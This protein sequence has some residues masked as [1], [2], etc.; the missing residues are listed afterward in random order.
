MKVQ[1]IY[2]DALSL[3]GKTE[4]GTTY[5]FVD[6]VPALLNPDI[7]VLNIFRSEDEQ[8]ETVNSIADEIEVS[9]KEAQGLTLCLAF[10][11]ASETEGIPETRLVH[12]LR[13]RNSVMGAI[14]TGME[15]IAE[16]I[17]V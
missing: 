12:L 16:T 3:I 11:A 14:T 9:N 4:E 2:E 1:K 15:E 10:A 17:G 5:S 8:I 13:Q 7:A 6:R